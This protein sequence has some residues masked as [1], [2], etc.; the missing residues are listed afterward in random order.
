MGLFSGKKKTFVSSVSYNLAGDQEDRPQFLKSLI[1]GNTFGNSSLSLSDAINGA[2]LRGPGV[3]F[4]NF[5][6]WG[7]SSGYN[8]AIGLISGQI[9]G[10]NSIDLDQ[11][12][13]YLE[14]LPGITGSV[15]LQSAEIDFSDY[16]Y[17]VDGYIADNYP[18]VLE[19]EYTF[20]LNQTTNTITITFDDLSTDSCG[21]WCYHCIG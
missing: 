12:T 6:R 17:W 4:R 11:L 19:T 21:Y 3:R 15:S 8:D 20:D 7:E 1:I 10:G 2:Y 14:A 18:D 13:D 16:T 5:T 9:D